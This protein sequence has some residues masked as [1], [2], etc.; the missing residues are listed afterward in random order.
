MT[1]ADVHEAMTNDRMGRQADEEH[2]EIWTI[3]T[4]VRAWYQ[5]GNDEVGGGAP[6]VKKTHKP[7][8]EVL[9]LYA[10]CV[11]GQ[12]AISA[13]VSI[14]HGE[15]PHNKGAETPG[16]TGSI[17]P[18]NAAVAG[19]PEPDQ[20]RRGEAIAAISVPIS[21]K[22]RLIWFIPGRPRSGKTWQKIAKLCRSGSQMQKQDAPRSILLGFT[23]WM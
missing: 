16:T 20:H 2:A 1:Q 23:A 9:E 11:H 3:G 13:S 14:S 6:P 18:T 22:S 21:M 10:Y 12:Y 8:P 17:V 4:C 7:Q 15:S 19:G 5:G